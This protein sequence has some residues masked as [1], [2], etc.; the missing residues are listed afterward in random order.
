[1]ATENIYTC[2]QKYWGHA[3]FRPQQEAIINQVLARNDVVAIL[4]TG[5]GKSVCFQI[6]ALLMDGICIVISPLIALMQDQVQT[7][8]QKNIPA[9]IIHTGMPY[10]MVQKILIS[11]SSGEFK[12]LYLSPERLETK[13]FQEYLPSLNI[14]FFAID[15]AHCIS[16]WGYDFRPPYLRIATTA[17]QKPNASII[18]LTA[19]ATALVQHDIINKLALQQPQL[20]R[21]SFSRSNLHYHAI[22]PENKI[23]KLIALCKKIKGCTIVYCYSRRDTQ[24]YAAVLQQQNINADF[25][26]AGLTNQQRQTKMDQWL[27]NKTQIMVCTNAFGMGIDK[28]NVRLVVHM[29]VPDCL[30]NYYQEAGRAGRDGNKSYALLLY[31]NHDFTKLAETLELKYPNAEIIIN[32]YINIFDFLSIAVH[33]GQGNSYKFD[34]NLFCETFKH[35][36]FTTLA[37]LQILNY[38][39]IVTYN[40]NAFTPSN[41]IYLVDKEIL[42]NFITRMPRYEKLLIGLLRL[43]GGLFEHVKVI[44]ERR[45]AKFLSL[46]ID[47]INNQ[48]IELNQQKIIAYETANDNAL[49]YLNIPRQPKN[50]LPINFNSIA[51]RKKLQLQRIENITKYTLLTK[52]CRSKFIG[53]YFGDEAI[54]ACGVCDNCESLTRQQIAN[55]DVKKVLTLIKNKLVNGVLTLNAQKPIMQ[56]IGSTIFFEAIKL[57]Q[58]DGHINIGA[59]GEITIT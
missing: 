12:F 22:K 20:F 31:S 38:E 56:Q 30:E 7:L 6:P 21:Q 27:T 3:T 24:Q 45:L 32:I 47:Y 2:L 50:N 42:E 37:V 48:L 16:Q 13:L 19:S 8:L 5:G 41:C 54:K 28:S 44:N 11:A 4:P 10:L 39:N 9:L 51:E 15:E 52:N 55:G 46:P 53:N 59:L 17:N 58:D 23:T 49:L 26:H 57:L 25:Y 14:S 33:Q 29:H 40:E 43:Y 35:N 1:M 18:A 34:I 36:P